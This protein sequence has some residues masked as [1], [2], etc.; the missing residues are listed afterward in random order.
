MTPGD[1]LRAAARGERF[2]RGHPDAEAS[3]SCLDDG[4]NLHPRWR[5][6]LVM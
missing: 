2:L 6:A 5:S 4:A 1:T 3:R